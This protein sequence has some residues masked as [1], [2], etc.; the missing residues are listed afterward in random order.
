MLGCFC[1]V[2]YRKGKLC[3]VSLTVDYGKFYGF[4]NSSNGG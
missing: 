1:V 4:N 3:L 2:L